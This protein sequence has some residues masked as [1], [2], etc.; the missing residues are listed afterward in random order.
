MADNTPEDAIEVGRETA[1]ENDAASGDAE[2]RNRNEARFEQTLEDSRESA[3]LN[4]QT[5]VAN[6]DEGTLEP[7][8]TSTKAKENTAMSQ[9]NPSGDDPISNKEVKDSATNASMDTGNKTSVSN[10]EAANR[11]ANPGEAE[12]EAPLSTANPDAVD[13]EPATDK[14]A[15]PSTSKARRR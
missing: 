3:Q 12:E 10:E 11:A 8:D 5:D 14:A 2:V 13:G 7:N 9:L 1:F 4:Y 15:H 6:I